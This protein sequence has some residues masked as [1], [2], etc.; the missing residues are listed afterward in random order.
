M[1]NINDSLSSQ[2][3][4]NHV[5]AGSIPARPTTQKPLKYRVFVDTP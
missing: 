4:F 5:V 3:T 1:K 2:M